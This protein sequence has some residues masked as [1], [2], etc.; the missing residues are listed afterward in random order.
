MIGR[1]AMRSLASHPVRSVVLASGFGAGVAVMAILLGVAEIVLRQAASAD[2]VGGGD[3]LIRTGPQVPAQLV[4]AGALKA[5]AFESRTAVASPY[6]ASNLHLTANG[7]SVRVRA[8]AGIPSLERAIG[9]KETAQ[10]AAWRN[11]AADEAW[12][13]RSPDAVL[14]QTDRFHPIPDAPAWKDSWAEW[15]YFNG[16][17]SQARFYLTFLAGPRTADGQRGA[18]VRLQLERDGRMQTFTAA[19]SVSEGDISRAPNLTFGS[20]SVTLEGLRYRIRLDL[21]NTNGT[22]VRGDLSL[23]AVP[24]QLV[25]PIEITGLEGWVTGYVVPV[26]RGQLSGS[27]EV[28]G[29]HIS[30]DGGTGYHDHNWGFWQGVSWQWGQ[31]QHEGLSLIYGRVFPPADAADAE[32]LPGFVGVLGPEGPLGYATDVR[33]TETKGRGG[34]PERIDIVARGTGLN[35]RV[36]FDTDSTTSTRMSQGAPGSGLTFLQM[37]GRYTVTG[38]AGGTALDFSAP[39]AAESFVGQRSEVRSQR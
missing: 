5:E 20:S 8:R 1:L 9:D 11:S 35:V 24:G 26:M 25:P 13:H 7:T 19:T 23:L 39:G 12:T 21:T 18:G 16:R 28:D 34:V 14:A 27:L 17:S 22:H 4:L 30:L 31:A 2:L 29:T 36:R 37:R 15:L 32:R 10:A 38:R 33:I 6:D 3:V